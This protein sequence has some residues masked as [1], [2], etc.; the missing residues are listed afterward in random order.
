MPLL[1]SN[2]LANE[3]LFSSAR[4]QATVLDWNAELPSSIQAIEG[5]FD[6]IMSAKPV[7]LFF[8]TSQS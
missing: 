7:S 3:H 4:P 2:I 8:D 5:G 6:A 1:E